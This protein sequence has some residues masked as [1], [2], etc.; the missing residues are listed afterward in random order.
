MVK[1]ILKIAAIF[2][3][4]MAGGILAGRFQ[5]YLESPSGPVYITETK[6]VY[7]E[8]NTA[9]TESFSKVQDSIVGTRAVSKK[10]AVIEG[11]GLAITSDG[12]I[13]TLN[14]LV[15][16]GREF[17]FFING[18]NPSYQVLKRDAELNL[19]LVKLEADNLPTLGFKGSERLKK[20]ERVFLAGAFFKDGALSKT[21]NE[22]VIRHFDSN[23]MYTTIYGGSNLNGSFLFNISGEVLGVSLIGKNGEVYAIPSDVIRSFTG[24]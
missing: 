24:F 4:G 20:G 21:V 12:L 16:Y 11:S 14:E 7:I 23:Y 9:L 19:A 6:E 8:E 10:G 2:A 1:K 18:E 22:G 15:P 5:P 17:S 13:I 3:V